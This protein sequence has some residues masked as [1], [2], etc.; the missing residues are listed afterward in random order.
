[1][2]FILLHCQGI[3]HRIIRDDLYEGMLIPAGASIVV[4]EW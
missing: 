3:S 1:M 4:N 2:K